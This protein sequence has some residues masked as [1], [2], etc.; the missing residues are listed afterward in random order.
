MA[1]GDY[2]ASYADIQYIL[3]NAGLGTA[4]NTMFDENAIETALKLAQGKIHL[5]LNL[6]TLTSITGD[7]YIEVL[8][9][10]QIHLVHQ[11]IIAARHAK[12]N[13]LADTTVLTTFWQLSPQFTYQQKDELEI[14]KRR[15]NGYGIYNYNIRTGSRI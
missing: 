2:Y 12:E 6:D 14:I 11:R 8:K 7:V 10:I 9:S 4:G 13:N 1:D 3:M 15:V 5:F